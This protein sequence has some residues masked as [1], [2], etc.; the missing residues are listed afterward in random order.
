M[1][2]E[3]LWLPPLEIEALVSTTQQKCTQLPRYLGTFKGSNFGWKCIK[4]FNLNNEPLSDRST[5]YK[6]F[7][8]L[9]VGY[10]QHLCSVLPQE[11]AQEHDTKWLQLPIRVSTTHHCTLKNPQKVIENKWIEQ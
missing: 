3:Q 11:A 1:D 6:T 7:L 10:Q 9:A 2:F 8:S 4:V 5:K